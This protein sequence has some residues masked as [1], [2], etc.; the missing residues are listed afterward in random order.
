[1][2]V[3]EL[4]VGELRCSSAGNVYKLERI[5]GE[6]RHVRRVA[7]G[8]GQELWDADVVYRW[9]SSQWEEGLPLVGGDTSGYPHFGKFIP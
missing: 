6:W 1:M 2:S 9:H 3:S 8:T 5:D 4:T 7:N